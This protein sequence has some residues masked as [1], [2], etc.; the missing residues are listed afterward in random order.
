MPLST[1]APISIYP[2]SVGQFLGTNFVP[3]SPPVTGYE[4]FPASGVSRTVVI[5]AIV[6]GHATTQRQII[7]RVFG[8]GSLGAIQLQCSIDNVDANF[9]TVDSYTG[10]GNSGSQTIQSGGVTGSQATDE[11]VSAARFWRIVNAGATVGIV[12]DMTCL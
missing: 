6:G 4:L 5:P 1:A 2:G 12:A 11:V 9:V 3:G 10:T 8:V 7:W